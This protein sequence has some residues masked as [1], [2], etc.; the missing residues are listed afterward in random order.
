MKYI[1]NNGNKLIIKKERSNTENTYWITIKFEGQPNK[2]KSIYPVHME[3]Q[4]LI[5]NGNY[6]NK[7][8]TFKEGSNTISILSHNRDITENRYKDESFVSIRYTDEY[9]NIK[10]EDT[11]VVKP[12]RMNNYDE[13]MNIGSLLIKNDICLDMK[14]FCN[15]FQKSVSE[16]KNLTKDNKGMAIDSLTYKEF[17]MDIDKTIDPSRISL[18]RQKI[19]QNTIPRRYK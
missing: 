9:N 10:K 18:L 3:M 11:K 8:I 13:F 14:A 15:I 4:I 7:N 5:K 12:D 6:I 17:E 19:I 2:Q 16:F 1:E